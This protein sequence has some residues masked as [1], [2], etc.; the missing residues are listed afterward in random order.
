MD[1]VLSKNTVPPDSPGFIN[2]FLLDMVIGQKVVSQWLFHVEQ[3]KLRQG[4]LF[5]VEH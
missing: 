4:F 1:L 3:L 2:S 5:H